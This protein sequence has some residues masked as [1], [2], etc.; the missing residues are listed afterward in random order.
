MDDPAS[1]LNVKVPDVP[2]I[3]A[4]V[5]VRVW[6]VAAPVTDKVCTLAVEMLAV[7]AV[8]VVIVRETIAPKAPTKP[9]FANVTVLEEA[10]IVR[11]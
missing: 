5:T 10:M 2:I 11:G 7:V 9:N 1:P 3:L 4:P 8:R 6:V